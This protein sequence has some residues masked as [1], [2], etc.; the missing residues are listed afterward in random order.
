L[1]IQVICNM[2]MCIMHTCI[3]KKKKTTQIY[4]YAHVHTVLNGWIYIYIYIYIYIHTHTH[5]YITTTSNLLISR[6]AW[7]L[8]TLIIFRGVSGRLVLQNNI[9]IRCWIVCFVSTKY[10][11]MESKKVLRGKKKKQNIMCT[12]VRILFW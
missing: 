5:K 2:H 10:R 8:Q 6:A 11:F 7:G 12:G 9:Q 1:C 3:K 4:L